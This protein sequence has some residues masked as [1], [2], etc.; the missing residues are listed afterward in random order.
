MRTQADIANLKKGLA[1]AGIGEGFMTAVAP[2]SSAAAPWAREW[3]PDSATI[4]G[5]AALGTL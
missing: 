1:A 4:T 5:A 3:T 2:A